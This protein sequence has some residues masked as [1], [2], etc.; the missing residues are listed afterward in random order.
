MIQTY[1]KLLSG[2]NYKSEFVRAVKLE[3]T[4]ESILECAKFIIGSEVTYKYLPSDWGVVVVFPNKDVTFV[5][6]FGDYIFQ[7]S[8]GNFRVLSS[9]TFENRYTKVVT[10]IDLNCQMCDEHNY[11][12]PHN[13]DPSR[14]FPAHFD[15]IRSK[16]VKVFERHHYEEEDK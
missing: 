15:S 8:Y 1:A 9:D 5:M 6:E 14:I 4:S 3:N 7:N 10:G 11:L 2:P 12:D 16:G 13:M